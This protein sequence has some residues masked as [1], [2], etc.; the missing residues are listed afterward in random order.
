ML[1]DR[2]KKSRLATFSATDNG[3]V[4]F[5]GSKD[6]PPSLVDACLKQDPRGILFGT[7]EIPPTPADKKSLTKKQR[8]TLHERLAGKKILVC[9]GAS[10]KL[11]P[12]S[13]SEPFL[14]WLKEAVVTLATVGPG[15]PRIEVDDRVYD[16]VGHQFSAGMVDDAVRFVVDVVAGADT[17]AGGGKDEV[18]SSK[19]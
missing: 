15:S 5:L 6:F 17:D 8:D 1:S 2:A 13:C 11:V 19:I 4:S 12:Y 10:D 9:S 7:S 14:R 16:G 3:A 18:R